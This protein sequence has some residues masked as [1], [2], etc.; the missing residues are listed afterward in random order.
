[1]VNDSRRLATLK[2]TVTRCRNAL[3]YGS[4]QMGYTSRLK[5]AELRRRMKTAREEIARIEKK[6]A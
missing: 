6:G 3:K 5:P 1:M 2:A 4:F